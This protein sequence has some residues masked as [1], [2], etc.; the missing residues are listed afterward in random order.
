MLRTSDKNRGA[1]TPGTHRGSTRSDDATASPA[2]LAEMGISKDESSRYQQLAAM[3][4][5]HFET[6]VLGSSPLLGTTL[7]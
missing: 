3:P 5:E 6:A 7:E 4:D 2:T 1:A